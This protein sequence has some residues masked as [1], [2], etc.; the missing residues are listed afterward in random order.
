MTKQEQVRT[1]AQTL[2]RSFEMDIFSDELARN[3][4]HGQKW[5]ST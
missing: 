3:L 4:S 5:P 2:Q 1:E